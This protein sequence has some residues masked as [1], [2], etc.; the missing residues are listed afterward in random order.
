MIE[1]GEERSSLRTSRNEWRDGG[2][3]GW[4][5][6]RMTLKN[7]KIRIVGER[8]LCC[9]S[10]QMMVVTMQP[11]VF[12]LLLAP[13][14]SIHRSNIPP[15]SHKWMEKYVQCPMMGKQPYFLCTFLAFSTGCPF[16]KDGM[17]C[18]SVFCIWTWEWF[19]E[20]AWKELWEMLN[21]KCWLLNGGSGWN[22]AKGSHFVVKAKLNFKKLMGSFRRICFGLSHKMD[23]QSRNKQIFIESWL[24]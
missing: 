6:G 1:A 3:G 14:V 4:K 22:D 5:I 17:E 24:W 18:C 2:C 8:L 11:K 23:E 15:C 16:L 7:I 12:V 20:K 21:E 13:T 10:T 9:F 19:A